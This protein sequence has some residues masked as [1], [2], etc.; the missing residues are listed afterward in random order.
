MKTELSINEL[1][2]GDVLLFSVLQGD[3][4]SSLIGLLTNSDVSHAALYADDKDIY[5]RRHGGEDRFSA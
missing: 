3:I 1:R 2:K 5:A 4:I